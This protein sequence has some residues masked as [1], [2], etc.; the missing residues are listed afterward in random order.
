MNCPSLLCTPR[1]TRY[2]SSFHSGFDRRNRSDAKILR[3]R[4]KFLKNCRKNSICRC[5]YNAASQFC[6]RSKQ[7]LL[8]VCCGL[9]FFG[10]RTNK[11]AGQRV[12]P[13]LT[14]K[15]IEFGNRGVWQFFKR[16]TEIF[17]VTLW[18][19]RKFNFLS[20]EFIVEIDLVFWL[21]TLRRFAY[22]NSTM[23]AV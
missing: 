10:A 20:T 18:K 6:Q 21:L 17:G 3:S 14:D 2:S 22:S 5:C 9:R 1:P 13:N 15:R 11:S 12:Q 19:T 4:N 7:I 23:I 16:E 8:D